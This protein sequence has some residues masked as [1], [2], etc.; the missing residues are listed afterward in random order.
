MGLAP[1]DL[2]YFAGQLRQFPLLRAIS[3]GGLTKLDNLVPLLRELLEAAPIES[4]GLAG[5]GSSGFDRVIVPVL[6][7][8]VGNPRLKRLD[9]GRNQLGE[10]ALTTLGNFAR[11]SRA[12]EILVVSDLGL[13]KDGPLIAFLDGCAG[14][15]SLLDVP[16]PM[17]DVN[18]L[19]NQTAL[20]Q[21]YG[22]HQRIVVARGKLNVRL[23]VNR[24]SQKVKTPLSLR[25]DPVL[26]RLIK[27][28]TAVAA[29]NYEEMGV[30]PFALL[31]RVPPEGVRPERLAGLEPAIDRL[32]ECENDAQK[33]RRPALRD[34][35]DLRTKMGM[36]F[37]TDL[38]AA[39]AAGRA[40][41]DA[42]SP[43]E[44]QL[45]VAP[46][47]ERVEAAPLAPAVVGFRRPPDSALLSLG[48]PSL[49][50]DLD[51]G[52][53]SVWPLAGPWDYAKELGNPEPSRI[54]L[55]IM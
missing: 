19:L 20:D 2:H 13:D 5:Q 29:R 41:V 31:S 35:V 27:H 7:D 28:A 38:R 45:F 16:F 11:L 17:G 1:S 53:L 40:A 46:A 36:D 43:E 42:F 23:S 49:A 10:V 8:L 32:R 22:V 33:R 24:R 48:R 25:K 4:L 15:E 47:V 34:A 54:P 50:G 12:L 51:F 14:S 3:L 6:C 9:L 37:A 26:D 52:F 44:P 18:A 30:D 55:A 39:S 21:R